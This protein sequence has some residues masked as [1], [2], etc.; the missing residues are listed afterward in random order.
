MTHKKVCLTAMIALALLPALSLDD[1]AAA[2]RPATPKSVAAPAM[3]TGIADIT[4]SARQVEHLAEQ[5]VSQ[6][7]LPGLAIA[8]VQNGKVVLMNG[9]GV[10]GGPGN[11]PVTSDTVFRLASLSKAFAATL[12]A[13]L[14]AED[15]MNW[16]TPIINQLPA[17]KLRDYASAK[18]VTVRDILSHRVGLTRNTYDRD[19]ENDEPFPLLAERLSDA[20]LACTPGACYAYQNVAFSLIGD[21]VFAATGDFYSHQVE[22]RIFHPLGMYNSTY[23]RDG[24]EG[25]ASWARPHVRGRGGWVAVRPKESYYHVPPAAGVNS[26]IH[27]MAQWVI[28]QSGHRPDVLTPT[29]LDQIHLPEV[30]T[31]GETRGSPWR[32][33]RLN[34]AAYAMG[35]RVFDYSGH[36]L[37]FH[38]GA[39]QGYR[40]LIAILPGEDVG[41]VVLWNSESSAPSGLLPSLMDRVLNIPTHDWLGIDTDES[42]D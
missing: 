40:G 10:T 24:L 14:V 8:I 4:V 12:S 34:S 30:N 1:S 17:F 39:V 37:L 18:T 5:L 27:D 3:R 25:S 29:M 31:P 15:A 38:G 26:S 35:W 7:K 6:K 23:G 41:M 22:K 32:R 9:F 33:E 2:T 20:P 21:L 11:Q 16:D 28:A 19:L 13:Q 36:T 42:H